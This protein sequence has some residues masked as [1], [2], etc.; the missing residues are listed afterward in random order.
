MSLLRGYAGT[1]MPHERYK[2]R[3]RYP[4]S[5]TGS[6]RCAAFC[7]KAGNGKCHDD[8]VVGMP[9][10]RGSPEPPALYNKAVGE[11]LYVGPHPAQFFLHDGQPV[12]FLDAGMSN[13]S[14]SGFSC[15]PAREYRKSRQR[16]R[17]FIEIDL[18]SVE[19]CAEYPHSAA[20]DLNPAA[21]GLNM[22]DDARVPL[23]ILGVQS[24]Q[25]NI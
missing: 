4:D 13:V 5:L 20:V 18:C 21:H 15:R 3:E 22:F 14:K 9:V 16:I 17:C 24:G 12:C 1:E 25:H 7:G 11:F 23:Y 8:T 19:W 10:D 6:N 2:F